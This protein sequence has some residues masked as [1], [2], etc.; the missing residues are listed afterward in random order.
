MHLHARCRPL[1]GRIA[2]YA[3]GLIPAPQ[4]LPQAGGYFDQSAWTMAVF[5]ILDGMRI[6]EMIDAA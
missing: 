3:A 2:G 5:D 1:P 4:I 6:R